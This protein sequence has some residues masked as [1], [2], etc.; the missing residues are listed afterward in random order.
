MAPLSFSHCRF[1]LTRWLL[2]F[3]SITLLESKLRVIFFSSDQFWFGLSCSTREQRNTFIH[4]VVK[5]VSIAGGHSKTFWCCFYE[6]Q[7]L[8]EFICEDVMRNSFETAW[9]KIHHHIILNAVLRNKRYCISTLT[10]GGIFSYY[11]H[12]YSNKIS[13]KR[14]SHSQFSHTEYTRAIKS[15]KLPPLIVLI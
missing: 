11:V 1:I 6:A 9:T 2:H 4:S 7:R 13:D 8:L 10:K 3:L 12:I 5:L 14:K 15:H